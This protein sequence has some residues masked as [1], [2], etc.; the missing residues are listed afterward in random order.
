[1]EDRKI[2]QNIMNMVHFQKHIIPIIMFIF[3]LVFCQTTFSNS[4][5]VTPDS[6][7]IDPAL[8]RLLH[9]RFQQE[10]TAPRHDSEGKVNTDDRR[11][12]YQFDH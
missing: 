11:L 8:I 10:H 12:R 5:S 9:R 7:F 6:L 4:S 1:M 2:S 3:T